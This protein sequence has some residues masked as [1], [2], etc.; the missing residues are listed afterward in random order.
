VRLEEQLRKLKSISEE[1]YDKMSVDQK[2]EYET[3]TNELKRK[4]KDVINQKIK[5]GIPPLPIAPFTSLL[6]FSLKSKRNAAIRRG[7]Q[8]GRGVKKRGNGK[9]KSAAKRKRNER[10]GVVKSSYI[11]KSPSQRK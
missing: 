9:A 3:H 8:K 4:K 10:E 5:M 1:E 6:L 7:T 11:A 2:N